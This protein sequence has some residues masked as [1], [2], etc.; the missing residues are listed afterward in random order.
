MNRMRAKRALRF[1]KIMFSISYCSSIY[2]LLHLEGG[3]GPFC[4]LVQQAVSDKA[5]RGVAPNHN[6]LGP[7]FQL[8]V[9]FVLFL[10][11]FG[12]FRSSHRSCFTSLLRFSDFKCRA[13]RVS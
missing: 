10:V 2:L 9:D 8:E 6:I 13:A 11:N 1:L 5:Y 4:G 7:D 3:P 12:G